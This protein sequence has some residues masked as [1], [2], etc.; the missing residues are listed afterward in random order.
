MWRSNQNEFDPS[1]GDPLFTIWCTRHSTR[2][3]AIDFYNK[4]LEDF[5][6][7]SF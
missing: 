2:D 4:I 5:N 7:N 6:A 1:P 3:E